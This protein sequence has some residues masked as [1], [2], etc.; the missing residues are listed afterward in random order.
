MLLIV[1]LIEGILGPRLG[2]LQRFGIGAPPA[3]LRVPLL[4]VVVLGL[5]RWFANVRPSQLG[6]R[7]WATWNGTEKSY[8]VQVFVLANVIFATIFAKPV[9][10]LV[11]HP[12]LWA[13]AVL[14]LTTSVLWGIYQELIYR[15]LLQTE[16]GRRWGA[17]GGILVANTLYTFGPLHF[18]H[19]ANGTRL[20]S[21]AMFGGIFA[22][23]LFFALLYR[24]S[25]NLWMVGL[26]HGLGDWYIVGVRSLVG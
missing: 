7:R 4:V 10:A 22:I 20:D 25:T 13:S 15:G 1:A 8:C 21:A 11:G 2:L 23:G 12:R 24:R 26:F 9:A 19:F 3:W 18:Y 6:F 5:V 16:L 14:V 17:A